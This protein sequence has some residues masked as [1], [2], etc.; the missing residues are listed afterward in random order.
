[1]QQPADPATPDNLDQNSAPA[2]FLHD[3]EGRILSANECL[4]KMLGYTS[5]EVQKLYIWDLDQNVD[6]VTTRTF[7]KHFLPGT[8]ISISGLYK[9][10][11]GSLLPVEVEINISNENGHPVGRTTIREVAELPPVKEMLQEREKLHLTQLEQRVAERT[12]ELLK[13]N[14]RLLQEITERRRAQEAL[15]NAN[16][17]LEKRVAERTADLHAINEILRQEIDEHIRAHQAMLASQKDYRRLL[18]SLQEGIWLIDQDSRTT[19]VNPRMAEMLGQ[20]VDGMLGRPLFDFMD[21]EGIKLAEKDLAR[22]R[23]GYKD[24]HDFEFI[25][26]DGARIYATLVTSPIMDEVGGYLGA[27][28]GVVDVTE[29]KRAEE[30]KAVLELQLQQ[31]QKMEAIGR[32]AGGV[33]HDFNNLLTGIQGYSQMILR[34][35][36]ANDPLA[37]DINEIKK[38]ADRAAALTQQLLAFSRKQLIEPQVLDFNALVVNSQKMLS[39]II[40][41]DVHLVFKPK[42]ETAKIKVDPHQMDQVLV[43]LAV[44]AR[45]AMPQGGKLALETALVT[46]DDNFCRLHP[47]VEPGAYIMLSVNDTGC[48][49]DEETIK[50]IFEP[51]FTTKGRDRGTGL[52]LSTVYGIIKQHRGWINVDSRIGAGTTFNIYLPHAQEEPLSAPV[53]NRDQTPTG[54]ETILLVEDEDMVRN[55]AKKILGLHGYRVLEASGG[56]DANF[57]CQRHPGPIQLLVTDVVMPNMNGKELYQQLQSLKPEMKVLYMSGYTEDIIGYHGLLEEGIQFIPKPFTIDSLTK[58]VRE[59][60]EV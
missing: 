60:L 42:V 33:A 30:Q 49:M 17:L 48:G 57:I 15:Q 56:G 44:N 10:K 50:H 27:I 12:S 43:N 29:R 31:S 19:F 46:L 4:C 41:E 20:T 34:S 16:D 39:R 11:D 13:A 58:K 37:D 38:A 32:L 52:G 23:Q 2:V 21:A 40:G 55:L 3:L 51:F 7:L 5:D 24:L 9:K 47:E 18:E 59:A 22:R 14:A 26:S 1:M 53:E 45:D 8:P 6:S 36:Q 35:L 54:R 25:K 28:A